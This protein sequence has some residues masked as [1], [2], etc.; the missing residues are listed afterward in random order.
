[1][2][3]TQ[4]TGFA[5]DLKPGHWMIPRGEQ[6]PRVIGHVEGANPVTI[7]GMTFNICTQ[8]KFDFYRGM[9]KHTYIN[10]EEVTYYKVKL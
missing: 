5:S 7:N 4:H 9:K 1:M 2:K 6:H 3:L 8:I 10:A